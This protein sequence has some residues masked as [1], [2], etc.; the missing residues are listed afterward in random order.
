VKSSVTKRSATRSIVF[1]Y[2]QC[3]GWVIFI[4]NIMPSKG[5]FHSMGEELQVNLTEIIERVRSGKVKN[6]KF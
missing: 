6:F 2:E 5:S 4:G 1:E 3:D